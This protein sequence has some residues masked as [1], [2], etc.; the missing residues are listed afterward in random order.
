M[1]YR[2]DGDIDGFVAASKKLHSSTV[3]IIHQLIPGQIQVRGL[4]ALVDSWC[5]IQTRNIDSENHLE[6]DMTT[7]LRIFS[8]CEK[9]NNSGEWKI[10]TLEPI[11]MRD[12]IMPVPPLPMPDFGD[13]L[14]HFRRSYRFTA[15]SVSRR[16]LHVRYDLPGDDVPESVMEVCKRNQAWFDTE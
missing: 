9:I 12:L 11:Y 1:H 3:S 7:W 13:E 6:Y 16:G 10:L 14:R 2:Y 15:W 5:I 8:Q 4:K